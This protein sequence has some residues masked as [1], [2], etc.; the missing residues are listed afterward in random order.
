MLEELFLD[1]GHCVYRDRLRGHECSLVFGLLLM[2]SR[3]NT[4]GQGPLCS[5]MPAR[6]GGSVLGT[7]LSIIC[8]ASKE[9]C[10]EC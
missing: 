7:R 1:R 4:A 8:C 9:P 3:V 10:A 2:Q 6:D 5:E